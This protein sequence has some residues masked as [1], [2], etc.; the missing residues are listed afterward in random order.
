[1]KDRDLVSAFMG[2]SPVSP[3]SLVKEAIISS[4]VILDSFIKNQMG[5]FI[6]NQMDVA[7]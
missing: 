7:V 2:G 1:V 5:S 6:K 3:A 4:K